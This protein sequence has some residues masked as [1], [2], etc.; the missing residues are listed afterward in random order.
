MTTAIMIF[1]NQM[2]KD[3]AQNYNLLE[4]A[5]T[6]NHLCRAQKRF[7]GMECDEPILNE[8]DFIK[9]V[10]TGKMSVFSFEK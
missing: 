4:F 2:A 1:E 7:A 6:D 10:K 5:G 8:L 9:K 3:Y